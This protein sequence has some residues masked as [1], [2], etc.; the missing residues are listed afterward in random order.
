MSI[1]LVHD[2]VEK[3]LIR[4]VETIK[5]CQERMRRHLDK[6][7]AQLASNR[8]AQH[9]LERDLSDKVTAQRIDN[10]CHHLRN[11]SD[12]ISY[13]RGIERL[14]PSLSLPDSWSKFTDDN[15]LHSQSERAASHKL[16]DVIEILLN[17]TSN[18]MWKHFNTVNVAFTNR[19]SETADAKN[20]LQTHLAKVT[21][22]YLTNDHQA[23]L[24]C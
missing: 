14:D 8:A 10:R 20:S 16:R 15:I 7:I 1:D 21:D 18:E 24:S 22:H 17:V 5:S 19:M 3:D 13:Y 12:G 11:A 4:E 23:R 6:A 2:N 9:E